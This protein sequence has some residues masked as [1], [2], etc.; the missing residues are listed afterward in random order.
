VREICIE[1]NLPVPKLPCI[2]LDI[3]DRTAKMLNIALNNVE[4]EFDAKLVGEMLEDIQHERVIV[5]E[6]RIRMGL[7]EEDLTR[8]LRLSEPPDTGEGG[9]TPITGTATLRLEFKERKT[10]DAVKEKLEERARLSKKGTGD[11]VLELLAGGKRK[12]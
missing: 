11:V 7:E 2:V 8:Y 5:P 6:E 3:D 1:L 12:K 9:H 4:G 10:R